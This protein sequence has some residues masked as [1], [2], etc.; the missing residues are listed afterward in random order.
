MVAILEMT[1]MRA[2]LA[3]LLIGLAGAATAGAARDAL[4]DKLKTYSR[5]LERYRHHGDVVD[6]LYYR[7]YDQP[8]GPGQ[9]E[10]HSDVAGF[11]W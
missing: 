5:E 6:N 1:S 8:L 4:V 10:S 7:L 3:A 9:G 11:P 2:H